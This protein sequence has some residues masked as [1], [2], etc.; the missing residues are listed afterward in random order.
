MNDIFVKGNILEFS[1]KTYKCA[2]GKNGFSEDKKEGDLCSPVGTF[3]LREV[4]YRF[5][6]LGEHP[7]TTLPVKE[8]KQDDGW[9]DAPEDEYYN[10]L[11][12]LPH[13]SSHEKMWRDDDLYDLVVAIGY[14]D[15]PAI[16]GKGSAI[17]MHI[18]KPNYE[19]TEGCIALK[20]ADL[21]EVLAKATPETK[22]QISREL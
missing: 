12:K 8:T 2:F 1:G 19:G 17:F 10:Q 9:C 22:I 20:K 11:V 14:N 7:Q 13:A 5:D 18:A 3:P 6:K 21:L 15:Q 16:P 4:F